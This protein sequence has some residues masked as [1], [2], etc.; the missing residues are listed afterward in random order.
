M[1]PRLKSDAVE[2]LRRVGVFAALRSAQRR[3]VLVL[4]YHGVLTASRPESSYLDSNFVPASAFDEQIAVLRRHYSPISLSDFLA[5]RAGTKRLPHRAVL[6]TFDDGFAN[7]YRVASPILR[8]HGVPFTVFLTTGLMDRP[9]SMIWSERVS[10]TVYRTTRK[11]LSLP[12]GEREISFVLATP[13]A[14]ERAS[15]ALVAHLKRQP[16]SARDRIVERLEAQCGCPPSTP[17]EDERY[18]FLTWDDARAM[19][20]AGVEFGSHTVSHPILSTLDERALREELTESK[21]RIE[22][23]LGA[24][25]RTFAYPNGGRGD[26]GP[27]EQ[28]ALAAAGY[29]CAFAL[30]GGLV[31]R[32]APAYALERVNIGRDFTPAMFEAAA[33]GVVGAL[34]RMRAAWSP[35]ATRPDRAALEVDYVH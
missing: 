33:A 29:E 16:P 26:F 11:A 7:N 34:G 23:E 30:I 17:T 21:R 35:N 19:S 18:R 25:C 2:T 12:V 28:R 10:R 4:A 14:R 3:R 24:P 31:G 8:A 22:T 32:A 1:L 5:A 27:R 9:G 20:A 13:D 15:R 6:V